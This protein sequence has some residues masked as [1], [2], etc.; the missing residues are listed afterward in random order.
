MSAVAA[1]PA[2]LSA[3][4]VGG[5]LAAGLLWLVQ[6]SSR[7]RSAAADAA[8]LE[9]AGAFRHFVERNE[10]LRTELEQQR[11]QMVEYESEIR[12][13]R[14]Q[15]QAAGTST[16]EKAPLFKVVLTGGPCGGK[17]T[18]KSEIKARFEQLGFLV[19]CGAEA[20]TL[21]F[22]GGVPFPHDE[23]S[24]ML[25]QKTILRLQITLED[26]LEEI[27][28]ASGRPTLILLDRGTLDGKAYVSD[29]EWELLLD[30]MKMSTVLLR[31][32]RYDA[33]IHLVTAADGAASFYTLANNETRTE[34][35]EQA[36]EMDRKT[37]NSWTG[38]EH[39]YIVDNSTAFDE[40]IRRAVAR[41]AKL[42]GA[43]APLALTRKFLLKKR[44][45]NEELEDQGVKLEVFEV[46]TTY[47]RSHSNEKHRVRRRQ[48]GTNVSFQHQMWSTET[49]VDGTQET[50][51][52]EKTLSAREYYILLKQRDPERCTVSKTLICFIWGSSYWELNSF[53]GDS[54]VAI[55]EVEA[56]SRETRIDFPEFLGLA[57]E[58]T[59]DLAYDS[60]LIARNLELDIREAAESHDSFEGAESPHHASTDA[61][62]RMRSGFKAVHSISRVLHKMDSGGASQDG[63]LSLSEFARPESR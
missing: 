6:S 27:G 57:K 60:Y 55:L 39:L 12:D 32:Q 33:V 8:V 23:A 40:K 26:M 37:L 52:T 25:L 31:D 13:L 35:P 50:H 18:A 45:T 10:T 34:T 48:Q 51:M 20:A 49:K 16:S 17:T 63:F 47:L 42:V 38:H 43:P 59:D 53:K 58:V 46:E 7:R 54:D 9:G 14:V 3:A 19:L 29:H 2:A 30:D 15:V 22:G 61:R 41:I 44:P 62:G 56:E 1:T 4:I 5:G 28:R 21:L 24:A 36:R 11:L